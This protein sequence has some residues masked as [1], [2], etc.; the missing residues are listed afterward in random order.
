M[1][2]WAKKKKQKQKLSPITQFD[3]YANSHIGLIFYFFFGLY[4]NKIA[5]KLIYHKDNK[6]K[7][8]SKQTKMHPALRKRLFMEDVRNL[9]TLGLALTYH[10]LNQSFF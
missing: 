10:I 7:Q 5:S 1:N 6:K 4:E 3:F 9:K 8:Q 2:E